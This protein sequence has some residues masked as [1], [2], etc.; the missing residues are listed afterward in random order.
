MRHMKKMSANRSCAHIADHSACQRA[1]MRWACRQ[2]RRVRNWGEGLV[3][4]SRNNQACTSR[5]V[6]LLLLRMGSS[7]LRC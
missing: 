4:E 5:A 7:R 1:D 3:Q 6:Q 2:I